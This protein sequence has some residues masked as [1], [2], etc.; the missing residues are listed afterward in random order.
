ML[1]VFQTPEKCSY[2]Y[3]ISSLSDENRS[4][5]QSHMRGYHEEPTP[6]D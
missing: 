2:Q 3:G 5:A 1:N 6:T 4:A